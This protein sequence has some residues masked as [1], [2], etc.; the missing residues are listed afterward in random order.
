[1]ILYGTSIS[2]F[3]RKVMFFAG[4]KG[5]SLDHVPIR[6][7]D[8]M[9]E[10]KAASPFGKIPALTDEDF[11]LSD[12]SAIC[13]YLERKFPEHALLPSDPREYAKAIWY[14][15][16]SDTIM[17]PALAKVFFNL[18]VKP[19]VFKQEP[20]MAVVEK[21]LADEIPPIYDFLDKTIHGP[22]LVG[23]KLSLADIAVA[24]PFV[25]IAMAGHPLDAARY[26]R[27]GAYIA[28][29]HDRP[30]FRAINDKRA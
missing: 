18:F 13:H 19:K 9:P 25:N 4:E 7:H 10:F 21:A 29:L 24:C 28:S 26:P 2:P 27:L 8:P 23:D 3:V 16:Y 15:K 14:D 30:A 12:S 6:F 20:D 1:M 11:H 22:F 5:V 17:V